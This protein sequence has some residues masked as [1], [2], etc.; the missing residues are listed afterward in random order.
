MWRV[1][2]QSLTAS[3][4]SKKAAN[5]KEKLCGSIGCL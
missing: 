3:V 1:D 5:N 4:E 2:S